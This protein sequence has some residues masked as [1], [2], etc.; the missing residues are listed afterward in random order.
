M[1]VY[2]YIICIQHHLFSCRTDSIHVLFF[3]FMIVIRLS[4]QINFM[5]SSTYYII[6][7]FLCIIF[8]FVISGSINT[9]LF[10]SIGD[11]CERGSYSN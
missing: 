10:V 4:I 5:H 11:G 6:F 1:L 3:V 2:M 9:N 7:V 8:D